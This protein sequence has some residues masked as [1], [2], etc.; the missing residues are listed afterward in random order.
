MAELNTVARPYTKAAF[1]FALSQGAL[2]SW[3]KMLA[4]AAAVVQ[5]ERMVQAMGSPALTSEAKAKALISVCEDD[6]DDAGRNFISLLA[7]NGRVFLLPAIQAQFEQLKA[8]QEASVEIDVTT[9]FELDEQQ[10]QKLSQAIGTKLGRSVKMTTQVDKSILGGVVV[11]SEDLV[12]DGSV[13]ARL[14]KLA[15][16]MTS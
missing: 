13:R 11:R 4:T 7:E 5:D 15:E 1:E 10:Q 9:A 14:A 16:A 12:I 8:R 6:L 3:S 2:G